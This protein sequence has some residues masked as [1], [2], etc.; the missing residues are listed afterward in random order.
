VKVRK[1]GVQRIEDTRQKL[2]KGGQS[3]SPKL[4][5]LG[6]GK[7]RFSCKGHL[8]FVDNTYKS[9]KIGHSKN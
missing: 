6:T 5:K 8:S 9:T 1:E 4:P 2:R 3:G 7:F